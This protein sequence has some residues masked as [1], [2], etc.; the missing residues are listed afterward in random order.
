MSAI[1]DR[2]K[3]LLALAGNNP[4]EHEAARAMEL[5]TSLMM[6]HGIDQA[7]L[8]S[9][10]IR[11]GYFGDTLANESRWVLT[12]CQ[13]A[14]VLVGASPVLLGGELIKFAGREDN[15]TA[16]AQTSQYLIDQVQ[17]M[18]KAHLPKGMSKA[19]RAEYR[20]TFKLACAVRLYSRAAAIVH[21]QS[22]KGIEGHNA[23]VV[24]SHRQQLQ[25]EVQ[26]FFAQQAVRA[27]SSRALT[28]NSNSRGFRDGRNAAESIRLNRA[29]E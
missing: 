22:K 12:C 27:K 19:E 2:I 21:E 7:S 26:D 28:L 8:A 16:A 18:Y 13:A 3:K 11:V 4:N 15:C 25:D 29:V 5:A 1:H 20:R 23:L 17:A 14:G 10:T 24:V 6:K 9:D